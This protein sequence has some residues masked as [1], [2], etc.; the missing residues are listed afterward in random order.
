MFSPKSCEE[1]ILDITTLLCNL[2]GVGTFEY[3]YY[4]EVDVEAVTV[5]LQQHQLQRF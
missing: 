2:V 1:F 5:L 3:G 4:D